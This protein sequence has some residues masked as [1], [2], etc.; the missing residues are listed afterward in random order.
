MIKYEGKQIEVR[1]WNS[2]MSYI[3]T[4]VDKKKKKKLIDNKL[5]V[6]MPYM[7]PWKVGVAGTNLTIPRKFIIDRRNPPHL[8]LKDCGIP[9]VLTCV[10]H[11]ST[12][13]FNI[14]YLL[15]D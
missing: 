7:L 9:D 5:K 10:M 1:L 2:N 11:E 12:I 15:K 6:K 4:E 13:F 14:L 8:P 3:E